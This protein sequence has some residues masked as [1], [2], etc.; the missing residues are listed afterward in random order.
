MEV[1]TYRITCI[2]VFAQA[3]AE[4][5]AEQEEEEEEQQQPETPGHELHISSAD[6]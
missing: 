3:D 6:K 5:E 2:F 4:S 1:S